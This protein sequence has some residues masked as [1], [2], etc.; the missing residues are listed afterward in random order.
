MD[1]RAVRRFDFLKLSAVFRNMQQSRRELVRRMSV[2]VVSHG[3]RW[4][5][6]D[7]QSYDKTLYAMYGQSLGLFVVGCCFSFPFFSF[8]H[9]V[10]RTKNLCSV[11]IAKKL[12]PPEFA[13]QTLTSPQTKHRDSYIS[14]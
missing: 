5:D 11:I 10:F 1:E 2:G 6:L 7:Y 14:I 8:P 4:L 12:P 3:F 9:K 13:S